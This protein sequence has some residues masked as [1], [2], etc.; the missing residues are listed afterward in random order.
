MEV[1]AKSQEDSRGADQQGVNVDR[2]DLGKSLLGGVRDRRGGTGVGSGAHA[3]L[4]G[5]ESSLD[6]EHHAGSGKSSENCLEIKSICQDDPQHRG[7]AG[8][9]GDDDK[10][11]DQNIETGHDRHQD[12]G[13]LADDVTHKEDHQ[14]AER[15]DDADHSRQDT[16]RKILHI[17]IKGRDDIVG[18][19]PVEAEGKCGNQGDGKNDAQPAR[20]EGALDIVGGSALEGIALFLFINLGKCT[21]DECGCRTKNRHE[22]H[23]E[24][25]SGT[26]QNDGGGNAGHVARADTGSGGDHQRLEGGNT[27]VALLLFHHAVH[28][29]LKTPDLHEPCAD[30]KID[31]ASCQQVDQQP[32]I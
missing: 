12:R 18:L 22:P 6:A 8:D 23:P 9:I 24:G 16:G 5:E 21:L 25:R 26:A 13:N 14:C 31:T 32:G 4:I 10:D 20:M 19:Q 1:K 27:F 2:D 29:I 7:N 3:C 28:G 15:Q 17:D 11:T 30:G